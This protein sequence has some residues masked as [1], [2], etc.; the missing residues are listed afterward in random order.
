M[1]NLRFIAENPVHGE[2]LMAIAVLISHENLFPTTNAITEFIKASLIKKGEAPSWT[3]EQVADVLSR[4]EGLGAIKHIWVPDFTIQ[5]IDDLLGSTPGEL[6]Q[7]EAIEYVL[8][9]EGVGKEW[10]DKLFDA[11]E[12]AEIEL[13][14]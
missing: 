8:G 10:V 7:K 11:I 9:M 1:L 6:A 5:E 4:F 13:G 12:E 2:I 3:S 14:L